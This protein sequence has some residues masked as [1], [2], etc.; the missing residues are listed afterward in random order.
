LTP[1]AKLI[2]YLNVKLALLGWD[3]V[4]GGAGAEFTELMGTLVAQYREKERLLAS[5]LCPV[6]QRIQ[7]FLYDYFQD[8]AVPK[9]PSRTLTLDR[10]QMARMLSL[11]VDRD[12][13]ASDILHSFRVKQGVLH[14]PRSDRRTTE[15]IFH[16]AEGG[17]PIPED[18]LAVP[19]AVFA[20]MLGLAFAPPRSL[21][22]LPFTS[23][24][25]KPAE[26]FVSLLLRPIVCPEVARFTPE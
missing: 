2:S 8:N 15:G 17:L 1:D 21:L 23:T 14:N 19:R 10:P 22:R 18:K 16:V 4:P 12:E 3:P 26:C 7:S 13:Y 24:Q 9:I 25:A 6:D 5:H 11:P 20:R